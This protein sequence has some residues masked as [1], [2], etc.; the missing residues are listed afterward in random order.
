MKDFKRGDAVEIAAV[1]GCGNIYDWDAGWFID[2]VFA[3]S[4]S[5]IRDNDEPISFTKELEHVR[6]PQPKATGTEAKVCDDITARQHNLG[7]KKYGT[8]VEENPL[9]LVAWLQ[10]AYEETLDNA[11]YLRRAIDELEMNAT[12]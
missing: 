4:V 7:I 3:D 10:H 9:P 6:K 1:D 12:P 2:S 8:T 5:V 11:I